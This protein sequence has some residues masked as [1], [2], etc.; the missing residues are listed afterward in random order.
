M[1][2]ISNMPTARSK[3]SRFASLLTCTP[4]GNYSMSNGTTNGYYSVQST[5]LAVIP[6]HSFAGTTSGSTIGSAAFYVCNTTTKKVERAFVPLR[7]FTNFADNIFFFVGSSVALES[8]WDT[9]GLTMP[10]SGEAISI[11]CILYLDGCK[12]TGV[13]KQTITVP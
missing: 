10:S 1:I 6:G 7:Y 8:R 5:V 11:S 12:P 3:K 13:W 4:V 2:G 9:L